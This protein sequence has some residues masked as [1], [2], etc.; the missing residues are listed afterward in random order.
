M[1]H[2]HLQEVLECPS[3]GAR[4][5]GA[6]CYRCG[7]AKPDA[8]DFSW[9]HALH[10]AVHE[11]IH[12]DGKIVHTLWVLIRRP[13]FLT[14][15]YWEGRRSLHIRPLRVYIVL[16]AIHLIAMSA[17][18]YRVD[19][20]LQGSGAGP[21]QRLISRIAT[22]Q[23]TTP[24]TVQAAINEKLAKTYSVVQ[25]FAALGFALVP[26]MLY[27]RRRPYYLQHAIFAI[28]VYSFYFL[29]TTA[30]TQILT[31]QQWQRSPLPLV[32]MAYLYFA[33]RRLY[34]E[35]RWTALWKALLLRAGLFA[36]EF[37]AL[38]V[39]LAVALALVSR[40]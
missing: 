34:G 2:A 4:L 9:K 18:F 21:L 13:G 33:V 23:Q 25:Y 35:R 1:A 26:W 27:R 12:L 7:E 36:A 31:A 20:F 38:G 28:H 29:L 10:D 14:A 40:S 11:F 8:H 32:T 15:E 19:F 30:V 24:E 3:C 39:A 17:S 22:R 37:V 5:E 16:A 6:F